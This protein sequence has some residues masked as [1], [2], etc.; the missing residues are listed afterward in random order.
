MC[1]QPFQ[2]YFQPLRHSLN[3]SHL[4]PPV[5]LYHTSPNDFGIPPDNGIGSFR[6]RGIMGEA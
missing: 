5:S 6:E 3:L 4:F 2:H 1:L